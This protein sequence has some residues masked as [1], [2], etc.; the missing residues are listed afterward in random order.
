MQKINKQKRPQKT[1]SRWVTSVTPR[2]FHFLFPCL[3]P[4]ICNKTQPTLTVN[5]LHVTFTEYLCHKRSR[6]PFVGISVPQKTRWPFVVI[7]IPSF[8]C[9]M[10]HWWSR[11][12]LTRCTHEFNPFLVGFMLVNIQCLCSVCHCI[13]CRSSTYSFWLPALESSAFLT[14]KSWNRQPFLHINH[15]IVSLSYI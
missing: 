3:V 1:E 14:Y 10:C 15:G 12:F 4:V 8:V 5:W 13:A 7:T 9:N 11:I 6:V 2:D